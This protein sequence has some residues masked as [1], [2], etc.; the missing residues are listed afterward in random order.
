[1]EMAPNLKMCVTCGIGSDHVDLDAAM[2]RG[3]AVTEATFS[4][5]LDRACS[6]W[7]I[8]VGR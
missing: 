1:M 5:P 6:R 8:V 7:Q 4:S 2:E 3:I